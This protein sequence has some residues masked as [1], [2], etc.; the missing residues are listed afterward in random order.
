MNY[1][2]LNIHKDTLVLKTTIFRCYLLGL[3]QLELYMGLKVTNISNFNP[4][5][6]TYIKTM[7]R[8]VILQSL[9]YIDDCAI[10]FFFLQLRSTV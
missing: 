10:K 5:V 3:S 4:H 6:M 8:Y 9:G 2:L 1:E 7:T